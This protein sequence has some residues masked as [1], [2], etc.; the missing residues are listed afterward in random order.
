M[1]HTRKI[2]SQAGISLADIYDV[3]GSVVGL[4]ELDVSDIKGVQDLGPVIHSERLNTFH[5]IADSGAILQNAT[6][7]VELGA[8]PDSVNRILS[9]FVLANIAARTSYCSVAIH[10]PNTVVD[11]PIWV[12]DTTDDVESQIRWELGAG[13]QTFFALRPSHDVAGGAPNLLVRTGARWQMPSLFF[14][15]VASGFGAGTVQVRALIQVARPDHGA[16][17]PGAPSS[18]GLPIPSW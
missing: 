1:T 10:D 2:L 17:P 9:I 5:L 16:P 15:G 7:N 13:P 14:R 6:W 8:F 12:W 11:H 4:E 18:H 3:E